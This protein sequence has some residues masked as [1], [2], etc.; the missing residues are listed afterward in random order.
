[1]ADARPKEVT[2][3]A[4]PLPA[5]RHP[6][7]VHPPLPRAPPQR[8]LCGRRADRHEVDNQPAESPSAEDCC[9]EEDNSRGKCHDST[10]AA[11]LI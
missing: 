6:P 1:M 8:I 5:S 2:V 7:L 11:I 9:D 3:V 10:C 4:P